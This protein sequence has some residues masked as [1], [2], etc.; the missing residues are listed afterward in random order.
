KIFSSVMEKLPEEYRHMGYDS[1]MSAFTEKA[2][3]SDLLDKTNDCLHTV[4]HDNG[5]KKTYKVILK[6]VNHETLRKLFDAMKSGRSIM[7]TPTT[8]VLQ[9]LEV[10]FRHSN[11]N[12]H[13]MVGLNSF[14][15]LYDIY[16]KPKYISP[17]K[18]CV[19]GFF[20]SLRPAVWKDIPKILLNFDITHRAFYHRQNVIEFM[21]KELAISQVALDFRLEDE[22]FKKFKELIK[23]VQ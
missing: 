12:H 13:I 7:N 4:K 8:S 17:T 15:P 21:K 20:A 3:P 16:S 2:L 18:R 5:R 9:M 1:E 22:K 14:L 11:F 6:L 19:L 23:D 10:M